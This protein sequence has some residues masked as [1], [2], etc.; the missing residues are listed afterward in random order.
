MK[1][2]MEAVDES[3]RPCKGGMGL[4][5]LGR[6]L[7]WLFHH[8]SSSHIKL[9]ER[10]L[11]KSLLREYCLCR[12]VPEFVFVR[13]IL[14]GGD[15]CFWGGQCVLGEAAGLSPSMASKVLNL[16]Y[17][18]SEADFTASLDQSG[19]CLA[20]QEIEQTFR[21][22]FVSSVRSERRGPAPESMR[23]GSN[24]TE[25]TGSPISKRRKITDRL[26]TGA[27]LYNALLAQGLAEVRFGEI[28]K[29][30]QREALSRTS[31]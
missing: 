20:A 27:S 13:G 31:I 15:K 17:H 30:F 29:F 9:S 11:A 24:G 25:T 2:R 4:E 16:R 18:F 23:G 10:L 26:P 14:R 3:C 7:D 12:G 19:S 22:K 6:D 8:K 21:T 28:G 5:V 1:R